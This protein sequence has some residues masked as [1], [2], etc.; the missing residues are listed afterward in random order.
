MTADQI[1]II[2]IAI[3]TAITCALPGTFLILRRVSL[4][5]DAISHAI[6][7]GIVIGFFLTKSLTSPILI[8]G[9]AVVGVLTV[10][11]TEMVIHTRKLKKDAAI[12]LVFPLLFSIGVILINYRATDIHLD[13]DCILFGEIAFT[14]FSRF[15]LGGVDF[16]PQGL[17]VMGSIL[18]LNIIFISLFY[19]ELKIATFDPDLAAALG[20]TPLI[21]NYMLM[22]LVS[23]T[24]V[25]SFQIVGSVL[26]VALMITPPAAA[27]LLTERVSTMLL[28]SGIIGVFSAVGGYMLAHWLDANIAGCMAAFSGVIFFFVIIFAPER[29]LL[30]RMQWRKWRQWDFATEVLAVHLLQAECNHADDTERVV[31]HMEDHMLWEKEFTSDVI[32]HGISD[33]LIKRQG[34][35]LVLTDYGREKAKNSISKG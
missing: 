33:G 30:V 6:L 29:G 18:A 11:L 26:V 28:I 13:A 14:P 34:E 9:A 32:A 15:M 35:K 4:M 5:S 25:G 21:I 12:G 27:Y 3:V 19:K 1:E 17:W 2:F 24:A 31:S 8:L 20:F 23:I 7:L 16:G 10:T 22:T